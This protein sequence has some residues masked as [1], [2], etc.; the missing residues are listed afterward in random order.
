MV[1]V[2]TQN[3]SRNT[4]LITTS[5]SQ[6]PYHNVL[7]TMPLSQHS[8]TIDQSKRSSGCSRSRKKSFLRMRGT[9][10]PRNKQNKAFDE[11][12]GQP[13]ERLRE[14]FYGPNSLAIMSSINKCTI[15]R[16]K[17]FFYK[18]D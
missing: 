18:I 14:S 5:L 4:N 11:E 12:L 3:L 1:G 17:T 9:T 13:D 10:V 8:H 2:L 7:I 15:L 6:R 16:S